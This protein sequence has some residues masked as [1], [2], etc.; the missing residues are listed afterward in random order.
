MTELSWYRSMVHHYEARAD[1][2]QTMM[3]KWVQTVSK[4]YSSVCGK[5]SRTVYSVGLTSSGRAET[6]P[7][8]PGGGSRPGAA[9]AAGTGWCWP[10]GGP[11]F[12]ASGSSRRSSS[13]SPGH[14]GSRPRAADGRSGPRPVRNSASGPLRFVEGFESGADHGKA[15]ISLKWN[16]K[17]ED[18][19]YQKYYK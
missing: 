19:G 6:R 9:A 7:S 13:A 10:C 5:H 8:L 3:N 11:G 18:S 14:P 12:P 16:F 2:Y 17:P 15:T 1:N 4:N